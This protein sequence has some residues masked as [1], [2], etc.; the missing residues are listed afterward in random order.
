MR[1]KMPSRKWW[2]LC[3]CLNAL[4]IKQA[5]RGLRNAGINPIMQ[6]IPFDMHI[7]CV[8]SLLYYYRF[9]LELFSMST[10]IPHGCFIG[11]EQN[12][13]IGPSPVKSASR[14]LLTHWG[15]DKMA[16]VSQTTLSNAFS[17]MKM[18]E[19]RLKFHW[20]LFLRVQ[21]TIS[22]HWFR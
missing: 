9:L 8:N 13:M 18:L 10:R 15:Q 6:N 11:T 21:L 2:P 14:I 16:A 19:F 4:K 5:Q 3:L 12:H 7:F 20:S 22:N 1:L 17:W